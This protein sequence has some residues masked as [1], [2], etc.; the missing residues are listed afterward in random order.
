MTQNA[1]GR[2]KP[3][4]NPPTRIDPTAAKLPKPVAIV[5]PHTDADVM[6]RRI[7]WHHILT[8]RR[9]WSKELDKIIAGEWSR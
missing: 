5:A 9:R 2:P 3:P 7:K 8:R 1:I 4:D 6:R